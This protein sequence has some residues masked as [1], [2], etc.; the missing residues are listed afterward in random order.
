[1]PFI[2]K[3]WM[4]LFTLGLA[5][6]SGKVRSNCC[7]NLAALAGPRPGKVL[8]A[9]KEPLIWKD[10]LVQLL[11]NHGRFSGDHPN[12]VDIQICSI[13]CWRPRSAAANAELSLRLPATRRR[14]ASLRANKSLEPKVMACMR[15][16]PVAASS[17]HRLSSALAARSV[18]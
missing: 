17:C 11:M 1:M 6:I 13:T 4:T 15:H 3:L 10:C 2:T 5:M 8:V 18:R 7:R 16:L 9:G 14:S 12:M